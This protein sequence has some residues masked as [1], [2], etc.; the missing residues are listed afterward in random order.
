MG[1]DLN[2]R[3]A[4]RVLAELAGPEFP[5][6]VRVDAASALVSILSP[7][8]PNIDAVMRALRPDGAETADEDE[9]A[10]PDDD[11]L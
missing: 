4:V 5:P 7:L 3:S 10:D 6:H 1:I 11:P 8:N 9:P 2:F